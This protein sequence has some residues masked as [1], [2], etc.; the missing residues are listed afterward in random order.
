MAPE[1]ATFATRPAEALAAYERDGYFVEPDVLAPAT[2]DAL[3]AAAVRVDAAQ[4][5]G[6]LPI[7][8]IHRLAP[9]FGELMS[10]PRIVAMMD[11]VCGGPVVGIQT[12]FYF[13]PPNRNGLAQHQDNYFVEAPGDAFASAWVAL[14]DTGPGNG[15]LYAFPGTHAAGK[16]PVRAAEA[17]GGDRRQS[18]DEETVLPPGT[19]RVDIVAPKGSVVLIHGYVVHGSHPNRSA[20]SRYVILN[21]YVR[22][23]APFRPGTTARREEVKLVRA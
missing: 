1:P 7:M 10:H 6:Q 11:R 20:Q 18:V 3:V 4:A 17:R 13:T 8:Q 15:G 22:E 19:P 16:L 21:T 2:C 9:G 12:Q 5:G 23:G 14:V